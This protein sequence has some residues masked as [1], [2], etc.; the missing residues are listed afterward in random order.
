MSQSLTPVEFEQASLEADACLAP[1]CQDAEQGLED[2]ADSLSLFL[3]LT[4]STL[5]KATLEAQLA[6][7]LNSQFSINVRAQS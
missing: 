6:E 7:P 2:I 4:S 1:L 3:L 5:I